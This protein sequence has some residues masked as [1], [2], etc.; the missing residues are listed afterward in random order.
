MGIEGTEMAKDAASI[1]LLDDNFSSI[2]VGIM[3]GRNIY[4]SIRKFMTF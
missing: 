4:N 3:Y 1:I 2:L